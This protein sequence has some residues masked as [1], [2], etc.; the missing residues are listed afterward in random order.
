MLRNANGVVGILFDDVEK[1]QSCFAEMESASA[2]S[3]FEKV[4][5]QFQNGKNP[6]MC[7][8]TVEIRVLAE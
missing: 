5:K 4:A 2:V 7:E 8:K 6:P 1:Q 3:S